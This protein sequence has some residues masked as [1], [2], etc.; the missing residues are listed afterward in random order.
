M[1]IGYWGWGARTPRQ[2]QEAMVQLVAARAGDLQG[3]RVLDL[4]CGMGGP[5]S[6]LSAAYGAQ[7]DGVTIVEQQVRG[8][9]QYAANSGL[10]DRV[11]LHLASTM[12]LPFPDRSFDSAIC[13]EAAHNFVDKLRF[14]AEVRRVLRP[15]GRLVLVD[16]VATS[17]LPGLRW[18]PALGLSLITLGDWQ[19]LFRSVGFAADEAR[20][21]GREVYPEWREYVAQTAR[22]RRKA[23]MRNLQDTGTALPGI[24]KVPQAWILEFV[25][26]RS[27]LPIGSRLGIRE[28]GLVVGHAPR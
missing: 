12:D 4:G 6:I 20:L 25:V 26:C 24:A 8:G 9:R 10:Q 28:Y 22:N 1:N 3:R 14:L 18:Q 13:I 2:A 11:R 21:I 5:A 17:H 15:G 16:I 27:V 7:V 19:D 23:I